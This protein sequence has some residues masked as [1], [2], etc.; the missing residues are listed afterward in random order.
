[1]KIGVIEFGIIEFDI[2]DFNL[3]WVEYKIIYVW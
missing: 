1:M 2:I 3:K